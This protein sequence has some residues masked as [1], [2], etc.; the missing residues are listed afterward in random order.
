MSSH[1]GR[2]VELSYRRLHCARLYDKSLVWV[3]RVLPLCLESEMPI[4]PRLVS[5]YSGG[6]EGPETSS[7]SAKVTQ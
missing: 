7:A 6:D 1:P 4:C 2:R 3:L 5:F